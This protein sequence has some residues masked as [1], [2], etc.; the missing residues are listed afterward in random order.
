MSRGL[1]R[2]SRA[3]VGMLGTVAMLGGMF[4]SLPASAT[5]VGVDAPEVSEQDTSAGKTEGTSHSEEGNPVGPAK[6]DSAGQ[7]GKATQP[8]EPGKNAKDNGT[9]GSQGQVPVQA[10]PTPLAAD[11]CAGQSDPRGND[12]CLVNEPG[13]GLVAHVT[14]K[15][16][17]YATNYPSYTS[18]VKISVDAPI[19][20]NNNDSFQL[21]SM[22]S[23]TAITGLEK[24]DV[25]QRTS[26]ANVFRD[27][28][29]LKTVS[30]LEH[31]DVS[32]VTNM[33]YMF[34]GDSSLASLDLSGWDVSNVTSMVQM[35]YGAAVPGSIGIGKWNTGK[36]TS[37][38]HLF[39]RATINGSLDLSGW[40][41]SNVTATVCHMFQYATVNG[42]LN[43]SNWDTSKVPSSL[44]MFFNATINGSLDLSGWNTDKFVDTSFMF[45][46]A[47]VNGSLDLGGWNLKRPAIRTGMFQ[48]LQ[49]LSA[50]RLGPNTYVS[51]ADRVMSDVSGRWY[52]ADPAGGFVTRN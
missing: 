13:V 3:L 15:R 27:N 43:L 48:G 23:L 30:G 35:F 37:M 1:A 25:S 31:W 9:S 7:S 47:K 42:S 46:S 36:V 29:K 10:T 26:L 14:G 34:W 50:L 21:A 45:F 44:Y 16:G 8:D 41:T 18:I 49:G 40:N 33:N 6:P 5:E 28:P 19:K 2:W 38:Y 17:L 24:V 4:A 20:I 32:N 22:G 12:W 11:G 51:A 52:Q 39:E